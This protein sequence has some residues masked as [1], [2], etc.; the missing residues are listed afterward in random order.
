MND[1]YNKI[2]RIHSLRKINWNKPLYQ[3]MT[4]I[5]QVRFFI[6]HGFILTAYHVI[7]NAEKIYINLSQM[8]KE[9]IEAK[10][11]C[12]YPKMILLYYKLNIN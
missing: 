12:M 1:L 5:Q 7:D 2:V 9:K 6:K 3:V 8:G 10:L 11:I 4:L